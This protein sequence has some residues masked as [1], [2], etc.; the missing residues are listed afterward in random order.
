[1]RPNPESA[2]GIQPGRFPSRDYFGI[3]WLWGE[4][5]DRVDDNEYH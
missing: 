1:M 5:Q 2:V 4:F 3:L